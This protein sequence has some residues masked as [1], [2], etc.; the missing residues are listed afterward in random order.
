MRFNEFLDLCFKIIFKYKQNLLE[1][2]ILY[3]KKLLFHFLH[4]FNQLFPSL[5]NQGLMNCNCES[6]SFH[7]HPLLKKTTAF[8]LS[9]FI[10]FPLFVRR[11]SLS[12][13]LKL[14]D[15]MKIEIEID[16]FKLCSNAKAKQKVTSGTC[17]FK[18]KKQKRKLTWLKQIQSFKFF[19]L[20]C[21]Y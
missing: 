20:F 10:T 1:N 5:C 7:H 6:F 4:F 14:S 19:L 13:K 2:Y 3:K 11:S 8:N 17:R 15:N 18:K 9:T 16:S 12:S 21:G